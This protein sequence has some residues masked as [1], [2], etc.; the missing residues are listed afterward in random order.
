MLAPAKAD[1]TPAMNLERPP[2]PL[3]S[4]LLPFWHGGRPAVFFCS[5][6]AFPRTVAAIQFPRP[7]ADATY[8]QQS[9]GV[10]VVTDR[11]RAWRHRMLAC[12]RCCWGCLSSRRPRRGIPRSQL[13]GLC[14][15]WASTSTSTTPTPCTTFR[16]RPEP[17]AGTRRPSHARR[18]DRHDMAALLRSAQRARQGGHHRRVHHLAA[19]VPPGPARLL[20]AA[21]RRVRGLRGT[22]RIRSQR[23]LEVGLH[24]T[25]DTRPS[26]SAQKL[27]GKRVVPDFGPVLTQEAAYAA[28]GDVSGLVD[29][30]NLH[31]Y[32]GGRH[33]G[34][35]GWGD[36][37]YGSIDWNLTLAKRSAAY[38]PVVTTETDTGTTWRRRMPCPSP[39]PPAT[40]RGFYSSNS[41]EGS[42]APY[43]ELCDS[44]QVGVVADSGYGLIRRDGSRKPAFLAVRS[45]AAVHRSWPGGA[46]RAARLR[47]P[48]RVK[49]C[50]TWRSR[51]AT[52]PTC[53]HSGLKLGLGRQ[54]PPHGSSSDDRQRPSASADRSAWS[55]RMS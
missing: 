21:P 33:P 9:A 5:P 6:R 34:T 28:L 46:G 35:A 53:W 55:A 42:F 29:F 3:Q 45:V 15:R 40:C 49:I 20:D 13:I 38:K 48:A 37:G 22:Q 16:A 24:A 52:G 2:R 11:Q 10:L 30:G 4:F 51:S 7:A 17:V 31:N 8:M 39:S 19:V 26:A 14:T 47:S 36:N 41:E 43:Y 50:A 12:H 25:R 18:P 27:P 23:R 32:P 54:H 44:P 1:R